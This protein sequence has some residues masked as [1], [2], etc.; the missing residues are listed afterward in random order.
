MFSFMKA[1]YGEENWNQDELFADPKLA[2]F[3]RE[4]VGVFKM[5][6]AIFFKALSMMPGL[7]R[8]ENYSRKGE[9]RQMAYVTNEAFILALKLSLM[10]YSLSGTQ[11]HYWL[12][13]IEKFKTGK[14][15]PLH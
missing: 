8:I 5:E 14:A 12:Q 3:M 15:A 4:E 11:V 6:T 13:Q 7:H 2:Y 9:R 10:D 1:R